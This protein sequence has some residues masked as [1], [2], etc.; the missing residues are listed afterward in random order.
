MGHDEVV[1][2]AEPFRLPVIA[3]RRPEP[4]RAGQPGAVHAQ[5]VHAVVQDKPRAGDEVRVV[6]VDRRVD[7]YV[8]V[9]LED[10]AGRRGVV[11]RGEIA[12]AGGLAQGLAGQPRNLESLGQQLELQPL[13]RAQC[14]CHCLDPTM[15]VTTMEDHCTAPCLR[16]RGKEDPCRGR[17]PRSMTRCGRG[18]SP[19]C[20]PGAA[21]GKGSTVSLSP[22]RSCRRSFAAGWPPR[23]PK[24]P[25]RGACISS[26]TA[27]RSA[28]WPTR[29]T[30]PRA[31]TS[32]CR[33]IRPPAAAAGLR[34]DRA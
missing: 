17:T 9:E 30:T 20:S 21:S 10:Q 22:G 5:A 1:E 33:T 7:P 16:Q 32:T 34:L 23:R 29:S 25:S 4:G 12:L 13:G 19:R 11:G 8:V 31:W 15:P 3:R 14:R 18:S 27:R 28:R 6:V 24:T 2:R 26:L